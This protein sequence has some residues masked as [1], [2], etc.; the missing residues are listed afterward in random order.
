[1]VTTIPARDL[2]AKLMAKREEA[3][4]LAQEQ[5]D[6]TTGPAGSS[7]IEYRARAGAFSEIAAMIKDDICQILLASGNTFDLVYPESS[8]FTIED[9]AQGLSQIG[10]FVGQSSRFYSVAQHSLLVSTLVPAEDALSALM[11]DAAEAFIGDVSRPLKRLL[12]DYRMVE[13]RVE[14]AVFSRF[15]LPIELPASVK[16]ADMLALATEQYFLMPDREGRSYAGGKT[17]LNIILPVMSWAEARDAFLARF[18]ELSPAVAPLP[19]R[20]GEAL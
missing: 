14:A 4:S 9:I 6:C 19:A 2:Y 18:A 17:P 5:A 7:E 13:K 20:A 12:S 16:D 15:G 11:H 3:A 8:T 1:M 10:R